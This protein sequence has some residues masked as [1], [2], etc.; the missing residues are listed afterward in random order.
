MQVEWMDQSS[1]PDIGGLHGGACL[2]A[3]SYQLIVKGLVHKCFSNL[4][5]IIIY[6]V[7]I[8]KAIAISDISNIML[9][10]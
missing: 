5:F 7:I 4:E 9:P 3:A 10:I 8:A 6:N 2:P 1:I